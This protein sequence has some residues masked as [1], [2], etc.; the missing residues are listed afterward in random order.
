M[1]VTCPY[2]EEYFKQKPKIKKRTDR[3]VVLEFYCDHCKQAFT[4]S[5]ETTPERIEQIVNMARSEA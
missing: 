3:Q 1:E 4:I 2:C 5:H